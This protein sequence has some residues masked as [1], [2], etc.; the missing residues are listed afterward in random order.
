MYDN[1]PSQPVLLAV[2]HHLEKISAKAHGRSQL[3]ILLHRLGEDAHQVGKVCYNSDAWKAVTYEHIVSACTHYV[4][5]TFFRFAGTTLQLLLGIPQGGS[6]SV[7]L[8]FLF[9]LYCEG[10]WLA[11]LFDSRFLTSGG[12]VRRQ[13]LLPSAVAAL[14]ALSPGVALPTDPLDTVF[15]LA[16][17][18][19]FDDCRLVVYIA[20]CPTCTPP[21]P[22][23]AV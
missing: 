22:A 10:L 12:I 14:E 6:P 16:L 17:T 1:L 15:G 21:P 3:V 9:C 2:S 8:C 11:S 5:N 4:S 19:Y 20:D 18:R 7:E 23:Y 13:A